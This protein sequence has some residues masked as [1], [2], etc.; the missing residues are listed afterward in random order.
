M[1]LPGRLIDPHARQRVSYGFS[2]SSET[3]TFHQGK[4][5]RQPFQYNCF[6]AICSLGGFNVW[7]IA[8]EHVCPDRC[9]VF[10]AAS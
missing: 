3:V 10:L 1:K 6:M 7:Q 5:N 9:G 2:Q 4:I 8:G